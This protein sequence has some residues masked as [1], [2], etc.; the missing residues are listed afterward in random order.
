MIE[1]MHEQE[2]PPSRTSLSDVNEIDGTNEEFRPA[3][4]DM[5]EFKESKYIHLH[6]LSV[7]E[8][9]CL[10]NTLKHVYSLANS[11]LDDY[12]LSTIN[13]LPTWAKKQVYVFGIL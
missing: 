3:T 1:K 13:K 8:N 6:G 12:R 4:T 2:D 11:L 5:F 10:F 9:S 7:S